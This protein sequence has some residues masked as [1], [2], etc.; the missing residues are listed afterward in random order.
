MIDSSWKDNEVAIS[1]ERNFALLEAARREYGET[2]SSFF[3]ALQK[4]LQ[5]KELNDGDWPL[6][7][8]FV[9]EGEGF[10]SLVRGTLRHGDIPTGLS[11]VVRAGA[12]FG[13]PPAT[14][15]LGAAYSP[16]GETVGTSLETMR[17]FVSEV[18]SAGSMALEPDWLI[19]Q[20]C[21][22]PERALLIESIIGFS[23]RLVPYAS[24]LRDEIS[25]LVKVIQV[26]EQVFPRLPMLNGF[27]IPTRI[28]FPRQMWQGMR[29]VECDFA[30]QPRFWVGY[31]VGNGSLMFGHHEKPGHPGFAHGFFSKMGAAEP[32]KH[33][34]YPAGTILDRV[35]LSR[36][37]SAELVSICFEAFESYLAFALEYD[38]L[39]TAP[40]DPL[41][42]P[43]L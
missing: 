3:D 34:I 18:E 19:A 8:E 11:V 12:P 36:V 13:G 42:L 41:P 2:I 32:R 24:V 10:E 9:R 29:Y 37:T 28:T 16:N 38:T 7:I 17:R 6:R 20:E 4:D 30:N 43:P 35:A 21:P 26:F 1:Y 39:T 33:H 22:I 14:L 5:S 40:A 23:R 15:Q 27:G 31:H 25:C